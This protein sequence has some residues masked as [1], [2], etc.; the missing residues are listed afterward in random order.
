[1]RKGWGAV[2]ACAALCAT[3]SA[4]PAQAAFP[5]QNGKIAFARDGDDLD[6]QSRDEPGGIR[7]TTQLVRD[8]GGTPAWSPD[9]KQIAFDHCATSLILANMREHLPYEVYVMDADGSNEHRLT[10][11]PDEQPQ[12]GASWSPDGTRIGICA[13]E[14]HLGHQ[15]RRERRATRSRGTSPLSVDVQPSGARRLVSET[16]AGQ[17]SS[18]AGLPVATSEIHLPGCHRSDSPDQRHGA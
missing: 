8:F 9:G 13:H 10:D 15:Q 16:A 17:R 2:I 7:A 3:L 5:G 6:G 11:E 1:M 18:T 4:T 12:L 14:P